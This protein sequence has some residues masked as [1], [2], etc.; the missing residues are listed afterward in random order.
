MRKCECKYAKSPSGRNSPQVRPSR[1]SL[2][3]RLVHLERLV[4]NIAPRRSPLNDLDTELN[5]AP[6][7]QSNSQLS[8]AFES[9]TT[10]D[11]KP[12]TISGRLIANHS[13]TIYVSAAHWTAICDEV[14]RDWKLLPFLILISE[15]FSHIPPRWLM[16]EI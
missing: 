9:N 13:K 15:A 16:S 3:A 11:E 2:D 1:Q 6:P 7:V 4:S 10:F 8:G 14:C 5:R 12:E